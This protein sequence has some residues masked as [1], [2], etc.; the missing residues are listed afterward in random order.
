MRT[1]AVVVLLV[2]GLVAC[3]PALQRD[4][5][6]QAPPNEPKLLDDYAAD[7][8]FKVQPPDARKLDGP[9]RSVACVALNREDTSSTSVTQ[10]FELQRD[11][12]LDDLKAVYD[13]GVR[14][15]GWAAATVDGPLAGLR[16]CKLVRN[17]TSFLNVTALSS[18]TVD[19]RPSIG[20]RPSEPVLQTTPGEL[21]VSITAVP[22]ASC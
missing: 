7:P 18:H 13:Q 4:S 14:S 11:Y 21:F 5:G 2:G 8:V 22:N 16:Y 17:V 3:S 20:A 6:C 1:G 15:R 19:V 10:R 12:R 9:S